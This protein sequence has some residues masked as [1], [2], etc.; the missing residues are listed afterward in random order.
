MSTL[1]IHTRADAGEKENAIENFLM[2]YSVAMVALRV[3]IGFVVEFYCVYITIMFAYF[4]IVCY[5]CLNKAYIRLAQNY[6]IR[7]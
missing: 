2:H 4:V 6:I 7:V 1:K 5:F 3:R